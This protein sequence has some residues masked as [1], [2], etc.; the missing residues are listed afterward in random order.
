MKKIIYA[1]GLLLL[2]VSYIAIQLLNDQPIEWTVL[3]LILLILS[4]L[5]LWKQIG[6][7]EETYDSMTPE[8]RKKAVGKVVKEVAR[9]AGGED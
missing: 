3:L 4:P 6:R 9:R 7:A 1:V 8:E 5:L 2:P